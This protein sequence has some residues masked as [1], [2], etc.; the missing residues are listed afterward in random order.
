MCTSRE[1]ARKDL[2]R[3][4][5]PLS[6]ETDQCISPPSCNPTT[7]LDNFSFSL[8]HPSTKANPNGRRAR[9]HGHA[10]VPHSTLALDHL[11]P[12]HRTSETPSTLAVH[13]R[14]PLAPRSASPLS[15]CFGH[16]IKRLVGGQNLALT[17]VE[18]MAPSYSLS[19]KKSSLAQWTL[20]RR[21]ASQWRGEV[22]S[23]AP[24]YTTSTLHR[25]RAIK[26]TSRPPFLSATLHHPSPTYSVL[27]A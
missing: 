25:P 21:P 14:L 19:S 9:R 10:R 24:L 27:S 16:L 7:L 17:P 20:S 4:S 3:S 5:I 6:R 8:S 2:A 12:Y 13:A 11:W 26:G 22:P 15:F 18:P 1:S 23:P